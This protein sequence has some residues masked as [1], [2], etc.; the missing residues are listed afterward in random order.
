MHLQE[1]AEPGVDILKLRGEI[2]LHYA[3]VLRSLLVTKAKAHCPALLLDMSEVEFI[4]SSGLAALIEY[5]REAAEFGGLFCLGGVRE[6][7]RSI[8]EIVRLDTVM[9][10]FADPA[11]AKNALLQGHLQPPERSLFAPAA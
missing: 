11:E 4:D 3:P 8:F 5:L 7:L 2:D 9:C 6:H 10:I 1:F